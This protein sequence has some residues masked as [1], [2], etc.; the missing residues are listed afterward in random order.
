MDKT[1][2]PRLTFLAAQRGDL[3]GNCLPGYCGIRLNAPP[4]A[5]LC[6]SMTAS[7]FGGGIFP[8]FRA[9]GRRRGRLV[10]PAGRQKCRA[11]RYEVSGTALSSRR[12]HAQRSRIAVNTSSR[13]ALI[14][15]NTCRPCR[16][17]LPAV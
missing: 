16:T 9:Q 15:R 14:F 4:Q 5:A 8:V 11:R 3:V 7:A 12:K 2:N 1:Q 17:I 6:L 10:A 13:A